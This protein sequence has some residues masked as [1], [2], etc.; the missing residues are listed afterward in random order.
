MFCPTWSF[1][2]QPPATVQATCTYSANNSKNIPTLSVGEGEGMWII[3]GIEVAPFK[4][5]VQ[6]FCHQYLYVSKWVV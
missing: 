6:H 2:P 5:N 3:L 1:P 4:D